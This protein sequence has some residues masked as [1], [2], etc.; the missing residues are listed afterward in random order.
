[1]LR[2]KLNNSVSAATRK[3]SNEII[4]GFK[5]NDPI[6]MMGNSI[7]L[8][9]E[10]ERKV[11]RQEAEDMIAFRNVYIKTTYDHTHIPLQFKAGDRVFLRLH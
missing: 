6:T 9:I 10:N 7:G 2:S 1:M 3:A 11:V 5:T 4:F 8:D